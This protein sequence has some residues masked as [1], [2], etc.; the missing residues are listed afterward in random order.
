MED[1]SGGDADED[2]EGCTYSDY[3]LLQTTAATSAAAT[4]TATATAPKSQ[5]RTLK[6]LSL[7][8]FPVKSRGSRAPAVDANGRQNQA[9]PT[10]QLKR[11]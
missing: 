10:A 6:S 7:V 8:S 9:P 11:L 3:P 5:P 4:A 2:D 1:G